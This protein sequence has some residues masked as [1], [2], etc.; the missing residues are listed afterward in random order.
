MLLT[1]P[2]CKAQLRASQMLESGTKL[3]CP[4]C[5]KVLKWKVIPPEQVEQFVLRK[6][7]R[8]R[9][10][11]SV[12]SAD[13]IRLSSTKSDTSLGLDAADTILSFDNKA[14]TTTPG[15]SRLPK[16]S[17]RAN[18]LLD[19]D[20]LI[21]IDDGDATQSSGASDESNQTLTS[22]HSE[23]DATDNTTDTSEYV[24]LRDELTTSNGRIARFEA[25]INAIE[26]KVG[27]LQV[28]RDQASKFAEDVHTEKSAL[29]SRYK[30]QINDLTTQ[31][32]ETS[33]HRGEAQ[34]EVQSLREQLSI[35]SD[36][37][38]EL[39]SQLNSATAQ[40]T[41]FD[42]KAVT[43]RKHTQ[44]LAEELKFARQ[45]AVDFENELAEIKTQLGGLQTELSKANATVAELRS[46]KELLE[47]AHDSQIA[48]FATKLE[49]NTRLESEVGSLRGELD[50][51]C[52]QMVSLERELTTALGRV[53]EV[54]NQLKDAG[55]QTEELTENL[56]T[57][58]SHAQ[59]LETEIAD[60]HE[61]LATVTGERET[62]QDLIT[63]LREEERFTRQTLH[64]SCRRT[65]RRITGERADSRTAGRSTC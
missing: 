28:E 35:T 18:T 27:Q 21:D 60:Q 13:T 2:N 16:I 4:G 15:Y 22:F 50:L 10:R 55:T 8:K 14:T 44:Q 39:E 43:A 17:R 1:C 23:D 25:E 33:Q 62:A 56:A 20:P 29:E 36:R 41:E 48:D 53:A 46:N 5:K 7:G 3:Y 34:S 32:A 11:R 38:V 45:N 9:S 40:I 61:K 6:S 12:L 52:G 42:N 31:L 54:E 64:D 63:V 65:H 24:R 47:S 19:T 51:T 59:Q 58:L 26:R 57:A 37:I 49:E 30:S